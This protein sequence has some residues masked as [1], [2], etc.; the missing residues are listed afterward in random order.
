MMVPAILETRGRN[1]KLHFQETLIIGKKYPMNQV[2]G[3]Q[4]SQETLTVTAKPIV[5]GLFFTAAFYNEKKSE[6]E[7]FDV[8][9]GLPFK[10]PDTDCICL[11]G[12]NDQNDMHEIIFYRPYM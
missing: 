1:Y 5:S 10:V 7:S 2:S 4:L 6:T 11:I 3:F 12:K 8:T 9:T